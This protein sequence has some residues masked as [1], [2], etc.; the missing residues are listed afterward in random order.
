L[1]AI[2]AV[3]TIGYVAQQLVGRRLAA[4]A[5]DPH[6]P[7]RRLPSCLRCR[8]AWRD[9]LSSNTASSACSRSSPTN[10]PPDA[11]TAPGPTDAI[12]KPAVLTV[13]YPQFLLARRL[14]RWVRY[15]L[16]GDPQSLLK[17]RTVPT[18][19][20]ARLTRSICDNPRRVTGA[21]VWLRMTTSRFIVLRMP[22]DTHSRRRSLP[23]LLTRRHIQSPTRPAKA[24]G[25]LPRCHFGNR[26]LAWP[27]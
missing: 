27:I 2:A 15:R 8:R 12:A 17:F 11:R 22:A 13:W 23:C 25:H 10:E 21:I 4:R 24:A 6:I 14:V 20:L 26:Q 9:S 19:T 18:E 5:V 7:R 16:D 1:A 3:F